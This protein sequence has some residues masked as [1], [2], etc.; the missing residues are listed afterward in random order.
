M[1][2]SQQGQ[3]HEPLGCGLALH[4]PG[5]IITHRSAE[6]AAPGVGEGG[7]GLIGGQAYSAPNEDG[8][9]TDK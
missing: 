4:S 1:M 2:T 7:G 3:A 5:V 6:A 8:P 9:S